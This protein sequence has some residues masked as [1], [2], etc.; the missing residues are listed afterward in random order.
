MKI[1]L[2][3]I[4]C[5]LAVIGWFKRD[6]VPLYI[7]VIVV[8]LFI[9]ATVVQI[10]AKIRD[11]RDKEKTK[12]AGTL[13]PEPKILL[14]VENKIYPELELGDGGTIFSWRGRENEPLFKIFKDSHIT[15]SIDDRQLKVS[16]KIKNRNGVIAELT[17]N[18]WKIN[19]NNLFDR[20]YSRN[21]LEVKDN[22]GEIVLQIK[23]IGDRIQFQSK[24]YD[25]DGNGFGIGKRPS[26]KGGI[27]EITGINHPQLELKIEPMFKYPSD[28]HF[29][30]L[31]K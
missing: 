15:I 10:I 8:T 11:K 7:T 12:Y 1:I 31:N 17:K 24:F 6:T 13:K 21:A 19:P 16:A 5:I 23:H 4:T 22:T 30:K 14:S 27:I 28:L 3:L 20:N 29:G 18:E 9:L 25:D 2:V 26:G